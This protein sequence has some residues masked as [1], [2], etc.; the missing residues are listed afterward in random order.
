MSFFLTS[1][2]P[3]FHNVGNFEYFEE[4]NDQTYKN[5]IIYADEAKFSNKFSLELYNQL[6]DLGA[7]VQLIQ[8]KKQSHFIFPDLTLNQ[9]SP[10]QILKNQ[11]AESNTDLLIRIKYAGFIS[12]SNQ[13]VESFL[14]VFNIDVKTK[15]EVNK[16]RI[17]SKS[18]MGYNLKEPVKKYIEQL[19]QNQLI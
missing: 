6:K 11:L 19:K 3:N 5:L 10:Y 14:E 16:T 8:E 1:C 18:I 17:S 9:K 2:V 7:N 13:Y 4:N 12:D 15:S